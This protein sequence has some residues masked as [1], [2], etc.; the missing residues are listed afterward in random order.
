[1]RPLLSREKLHQPKYPR[2]SNQIITCNDERHLNLIDTDL[3]YSDPA[4]QFLRDKNFT[5]DHVFSEDASNEE[6]YIKLL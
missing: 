2:Q 1:V 4:G 5:F 3:M 6:V